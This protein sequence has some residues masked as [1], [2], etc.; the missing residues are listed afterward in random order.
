MSNADQGDGYFRVTT[1]ACLFGNLVALHVRWPGNRVG[2]KFPINLRLEVDEYQLDISARPSLRRRVRQRLT[3]QVDA[4]DQKLRLRIRL[5]FCYVRYHETAV[6]IVGESKYQSAIEIGK[7]EEH[8]SEKSQ[9]VQKSGWQAGVA[10]KITSNPTFD[11]S[12]GVYLNAGLDHRQN[13]V[14]EISALT[15]PVILGVMAVPN[16]WRVGDPK[17][18]DPL[19]TFSFL[20]GRYFD[21]SNPDFQHTCEAE[22]VKGASSGQ[23]TFTVAVGEGLHVERVDGGNSNGEEKAA[24]EMEMRDKIAALRVE[25]ELTKDEQVRSGG[26]LPLMTVRCDVMRG[27]E[28][29][30]VDKMPAQSSGLLATPAPPDHPPVRRGRPPQRQ[31]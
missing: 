6:K 14:T 11:T 27:V 21:R 5:K 10:G 29:E 26:E 31:V 1:T 20:A 17:R 4:E 8:R 2:S 16:G 22:F 24:A 19:Q 15:T 28:S 23:L 30:L 13:E 3:G 18:G 12:A 25:R 7:Y 9:A